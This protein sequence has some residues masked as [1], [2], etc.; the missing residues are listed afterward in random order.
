M[1][2]VSVI[3]ISML[4]SIIERRGVRKI[5]WWHVVTFLQWIKDNNPNPCIISTCRKRSKL[6]RIPVLASAQFEKHRVAEGERQV[7]DP[8]LL[9]LLNW[10]LMVGSKDLLN[11]SNGAGR[12]MIECNEGCFGVRR[13]RISLWN[14]KSTITNI[15]FSPTLITSSD[16][17]ILLLLLLLL[18]TYAVVVGNKTK[19]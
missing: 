9:R 7:N 18:L 6:S 11:M 10:P 13:L 8:G 15:A 19:I 16:H 1:D 4:F 17:L 12:I 5:H 3:E 2:R 14:N